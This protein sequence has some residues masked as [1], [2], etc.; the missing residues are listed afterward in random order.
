MALR[1]ISVEA[2]FDAVLE[3][4]SSS[5]PRASRQEQTSLTGWSN[6]AEMAAPQSASAL[7]VMTTY[8]RH[9]EGFV[10]VSG[11]LNRYMAAHWNHVLAMGARESAYCHP[12]SVGSIHSVLLWYEAPV[13]GPEE[14][15]EG[16]LRRQ[17]LWLAK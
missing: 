9:V 11:D 5:V 6:A 2:N 3:A 13:S 7:L 10:Q 8:D 17:R 4:I 14:A 16:I 15:V 1:S 12:E